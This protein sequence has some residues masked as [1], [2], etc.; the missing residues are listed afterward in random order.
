MNGVEFRTI[1]QGLGVTAEWLAHRLGVQTR[2]VERWEA[3]D[4]SIPAVA[5]AELASLL[6]EAAGQVKAHVKAF[7]AHPQ[8]P[9]L[10]ALEDDDWPVGWQ[11]A[12][13]FRVL[14]KVVGVE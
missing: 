14:L 3:G 4:R 9:P 2:A 11:R 10:L 13:A 7:R 6:R 12:V 1:R 5:E 8:V